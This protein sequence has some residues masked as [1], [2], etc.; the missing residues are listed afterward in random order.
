ML[1]SEAADK[2][3]AAAAERAREDQTITAETGL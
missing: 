2:G 3:D 1:W